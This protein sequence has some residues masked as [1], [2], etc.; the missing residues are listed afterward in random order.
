MD[1]TKIALPYWLPWATTAI[2]AALVACVGELWLIER[3]RNELLSEE[4]AVAATVLKSSQNQLEA[5]RIVSG[6]ELSRLGSDLSVA[7][8]SPMPGGPSGACGAVV[9][10]PNQGHGVLTVYGLA[11]SSPTE[12][13]QLWMT[14]A[15][16]TSHTSESSCAVFAPPDAK[17]PFHHGID[18]AAPESDGPGFVLVLGKKG[19]A[20]TLKEALEGGSI[21]LASPRR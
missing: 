15:D 5:E 16:A 6:R 20:A 11:P 10:N 19:G 2:L 12:D 9:W 21:V 7:F 14:R 4:T 8:L 13:F 3:A 18:I 17:G 1:E